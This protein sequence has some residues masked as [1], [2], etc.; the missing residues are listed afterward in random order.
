MTCTIVFIHRYGIDLAGLR[1]SKPPHTRGEPL[2]NPPEGLCGAGDS[3][4]HDYNNSNDYLS[5]AEGLDSLK[6]SHMTWS[7]S[8]LSRRNPNPQ[9]W[10]KVKVIKSLTAG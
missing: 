1:P 2:V 10:A 8:H 7:G 9:K 5:R 3:A 4:T 6:F